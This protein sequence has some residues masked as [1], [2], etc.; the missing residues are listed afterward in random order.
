MKYSLKLI[1][2]LSCFLVAM[3]VGC[4]ESNPV[5]TGFTSQN[6]YS[7]NLGTTSKDVALGGSLVFSAIVRDA[8]G[9]IVQSSAHPITF[10]TDRGGQFTPIQVPIANGIAQA[11]YVAPQ[12]VAATNMRAQELET[13]AVEIPKIDSLP[14]PT[15]V[16][17]DLPFFETVT[18][19]FQGAAAKITLHVFKP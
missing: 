17:S 7:I 16:T 8:D 6:G 13:P 15:T 14:A 12:Y 11:V 9:D 5:S 1:I 2:I 18:A 4:S 19:S 10:T 3:T